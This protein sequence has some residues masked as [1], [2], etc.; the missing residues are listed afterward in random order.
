ME[1]LCTLLGVRAPGVSALEAWSP[2]AHAALRL[3]STALVLTRHGEAVSVGLL[4]RS[5]QRAAGL[6]A[7]VLA[8]SGAGGRHLPEDDAA[9]QASL[10]HVMS[11]CGL[12][13]EDALQARMATQQGTLVSPWAAAL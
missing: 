9:W 7:V 4:Q 13:A 8:Y 12:E 5:G 2:F 6:T 3:G 1:E 10:A 11:C